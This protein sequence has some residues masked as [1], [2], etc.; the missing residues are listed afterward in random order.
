MDLS[1]YTAK[2]DLKNA[3]GIDTS[4]LAAKSNLAS[5]KAEVDQTDVDKLKTVRID[6]NKLSKAVKNEV[7]KKK[8]CIIN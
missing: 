6:L 8:L 5:L 3:A 4:K 7:V 2:S 1:N